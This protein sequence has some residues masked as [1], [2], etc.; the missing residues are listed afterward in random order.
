VHS[1]GDAATRQT[2]DG[3]EALQRANG[4]R[5]RRHRVEHIELIHPADIPRFKQLGVLGSMQPSHCPAAAD[6]SDVWPARVGRERWPF[7]IVW[8]TLREAGVHLAFGSDWPVVNF[9]PMLGV[10]AALN[11]RPWAPGQPEQRQTLMDTLAGYTRDAAYAE[12]MGGRKGQLRPG[13]LADLVLLS[14]D[15]EQTPAEAVAEVHPVL[16]MVDGRVVYEG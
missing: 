5:D 13:R 8:Q 16:T 14:A 9:N 11:R 3:F 1:I 15:L 12:F 7:S 6:G 2:L 4:S 10:H